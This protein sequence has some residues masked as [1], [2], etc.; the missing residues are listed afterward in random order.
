MKRDDHSARAIYDCRQGQTSILGSVFTMASC[1]CV[2]EWARSVHTGVQGTSIVGM[3]AA[4]E[5]IEPGRLARFLGREKDVAASRV[6][7]SNR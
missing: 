7:H 4:R 5:A 1:R 3:E 2:F 6:A